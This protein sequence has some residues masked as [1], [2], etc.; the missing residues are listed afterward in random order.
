MNEIF[1]TKSFFKRSLDDLDTSMND[2][3]AKLD[4]MKIIEVG[5]DILSPDVFKEENYRF[6][7]VIK[8]LTEKK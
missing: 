5:Y 8:Y 6:V 2:F 7:G 4:P 1:Q 3:L